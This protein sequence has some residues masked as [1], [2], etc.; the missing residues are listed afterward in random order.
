MPSIQENRRLLI[1]LPGR[2]LVDP[3]L[4]HAGRQALK[5]EYR[6]TATQCDGKGAVLQP[7]VTQPPDA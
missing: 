1:A 5:N 2:E 3:P 7:M 4:R 6:C